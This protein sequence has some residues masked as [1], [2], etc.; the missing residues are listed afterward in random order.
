MPVNV[1]IVGF[2]YWGPNVTRNFALSPKARILAICDTREDRVAIAAAAYP[3]VLA[4]SDFEEVLRDTR[5]SLIA[6]AT[7]VSSHYA[8]G[9]RAL[10]AGKHLLIEKPMAAS[11]EES[12]SLIALAK[13]QGLHIFVD[14]TFVFTAAVQK[15]KTLCSA[16][17]LGRLLYYDSSRINLGLFQH[18]VDVVWDL[19]P[20]DL[21]ILDFV[22]DGML[23][24]SVS[25]WG[26]SHYGNLADQ[27][28]IALKYANNFIAHVHVNWVAPVKVRQVLF[29]GDKKMIVYD[30]NTVFEKVR[31]YDRSVRMPSADEAYKWLVQ[32]REGDM[33]APRLDNTEALAVEVANIVETIAGNESALV[34]G[35]AG[36]R[37]VHILEAASESLRNGG[38]SILVDPRS[39]TVRP[40]H[41]QTDEW[42]QA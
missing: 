6:L 26:V 38:R 41:R 35:D 31:V 16:G 19:L 1:G 36:A 24:E 27:A 22:L 17:D 2:G 20:H 30:E 40:I 15:I 12:R 37:V 25:C 14:H 10:E 33:L 21:S 9:I 7:P 28:Y 5:I 23:P 8:L 34:D 4:T 3:G 18:D 42:S 39:G 29:C 11:L 13:R 32:Y